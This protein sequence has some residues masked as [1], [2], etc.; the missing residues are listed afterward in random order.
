MSAVH[1]TDDSFQAEVLQ[2]DIPVLVD[3][4]ASW[5]GPCQ[6]M[7]PV[8][9]ALSGDF[10]GKVKVGKLNVDENPKTAQEYGIMSIPAFKVFQNGEV[11]GEI[12]GAMPKDA[13]VEKLNAIVG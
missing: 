1:F 3:F 6:M 4:W 10:A 5:C 9:D 7:G 2:S 11:I 13:F 8:I 12:V